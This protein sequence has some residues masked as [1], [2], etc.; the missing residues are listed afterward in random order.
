MWLL[1]GDILQRIAT[2]NMDT[3]NMSHIDP[4]RYSNA[5]NQGTQAICAEL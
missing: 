5:I 2:I 4:R 3:D 1:R